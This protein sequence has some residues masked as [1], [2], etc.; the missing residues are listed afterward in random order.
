M[1]I[2]FTRRKMKNF[3][4]LKGILPKSGLKMYY[5]E[6][7]KERFNEEKIT[8]PTDNTRK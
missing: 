7:E 3:N 5:Q 8:S 2:K 1:P 4:K 6:K